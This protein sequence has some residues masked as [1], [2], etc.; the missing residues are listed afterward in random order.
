MKNAEAKPFGDLKTAKV[1]VIG[2][3]PR[4]QKSNTIAEYCFFADY[5][6]RPLP[7]SPSEL[8]KY[9]LAE[10]LFSI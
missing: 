6:F 5:F 7:K 1:L 3:D 9:K 10:S 4:L 8:R 2:H